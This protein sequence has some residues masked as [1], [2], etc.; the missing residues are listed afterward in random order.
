MKP[1]R[2]LF[3]ATSLLCVVSAVLD[4][5]VGKDATLIYVAVAQVLALIGLLLTDRRPENRI[6]WVFAVS[7]LGLAVG[8][9]CSAYAVLALVDDPGSLP[10][11][12]AAAWVDNWGWLP[13]L[14]LPL[15]ALLLL[16]PDGHLPS[17][18]WRPAAGALVVGTALGVFAISVSPTFDLG[19]GA[20]VDNPLALDGWF[21]AV[22]GSVGFTL[23]LGGLVASF[24]AF[25][26]RLRHATGDERQQLRWIGLSLVV[27]A[28][29]GIVG[30][31]LWGRLPLGTFLPA[32]SVVAYS[33][34]VAIAV[35]RYRLYEIDRI[36]SK[37]LVYAVVTVI[38]AGAYVG[39]VLAGQA[40]FSFFAGGSNLA[41][42][43]STLVVA[44][45]FLPLRARIQRVVDRRFYRRR[46][47]AQRTLEAF[48]ARMREELDLETLAFELRGVAVDTMEPV[49]AS[50]WLREGGA[51]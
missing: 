51:P 36:V 14:V 40:L 49:H 12:L 37:T 44:A 10:G 2:A 42:A 17:A 19:T 27:A 26:A 24:V 39:L 5:R 45:L 33:L 6:S 38:L 31:A 41:I 7:A 11:G 15:C 25:A 3:V 16:V 8:N 9:F 13:G 48:G 30:V 43:V 47:D 29:L 46:H 50:L 23:V 4:V 22:V 18:R 35:L 20:P 28:V 34:G 1:G 21:V 32:L